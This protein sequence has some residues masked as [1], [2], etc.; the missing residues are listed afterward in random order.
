MDDEDALR[1]P[2]RSGLDQFHETALNKLP[3][4]SLMQLT[5]VIQQ[6]RG[7]SE[8]EILRDDMRAE[9][10]QQLRERRLATQRAS[11]SR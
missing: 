9:F 2:R 1:T 6:G 11:A 7:S 8:F 5:L 10:A 4:K 3:F